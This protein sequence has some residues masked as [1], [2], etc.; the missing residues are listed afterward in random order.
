MWVTIIG[1]VLMYGLVVQTTRPD[2][3]ILTSSIAASYLLYLQ[4]SALSSNDNSVNNKNFGSSS[5]TTLQIFAGLSFTII[6]L[7]IISSSSKK[8]DDTNIAA[9]ASGHLVEAEEDL[10]DKQDIEKPMVG[11]GGNKD[12][13]VFAVT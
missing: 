12:H 4:W 6:C 7:V 9:T 5:N 8:A 10:D 1:I 11:G 3:S 13:H 2:A